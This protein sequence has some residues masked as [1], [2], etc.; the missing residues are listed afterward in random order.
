MF[1]IHICFS[2]SLK[3]SIVLL[4]AIMDLE[5]AL[6]IESIWL[7]VLYSLSRNRYR[8]IVFIA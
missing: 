2:V 7:R 5:L 6:C 4:Y 1:I 8:F 3:E